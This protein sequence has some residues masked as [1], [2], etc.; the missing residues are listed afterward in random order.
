MNI[1]NY[2]KQHSNGSNSSSH[3]SNKT[4]FV[5]SPVLYMTPMAPIDYGC[6]DDIL[7]D[8]KSDSNMTP[9]SQT[10]SPMFTGENEAFG[11]LEFLDSL[12]FELKYGSH[13]SQGNRK[14]MEDRHKIKIGLDNN[15]H[16]SL[17]GVFDGHGGERASNFVKKKIVNCLN[18]FVKENKAGYSSKNSY[19][20]PTN[21]NCSSSSSTSSTT[22]TTPST[23]SVTSPPSNIISH[24]IN[25]SSS[26]VG[27]SA[28]NSSTGIGGGHC[29][30]NPPNSQPLLIVANAG[31]SRGVLCR[32]G[33]A[34]PL[35]YDHKPGNPKEKQRISSAGGKI[36]WDYNERIWRVSGILSV[37]RGIGDIPL[38]K[39]VICD[40]EFVVFPLKGPSIR[41]NRVH[42][43][44]SSA[45]ASPTSSTPKAFKSSP[46]MNS[47][48]F[49]SPSFKNKPVT[50]SPSQSN[51]PQIFTP[52][53]N[54]S[55]Y[56]QNNGI[57]SPSSSIASETP[58]LNS[59]DHRNHNHSNINNHSL[60][61]P[62]P[63]S[64]SH[65]N[66]H[67][68]HKM[69]YCSNHQF[70]YGEV[71]QFFVLATDGIWDVFENQELVDFINENIEEFYHSKRIDWDANEISKKVVQ[72]AYRRGSGDNTTVLIIKLYW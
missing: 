72:E 65:H 66:H 70:N 6:P 55:N 36:E 71:D 49:F 21:S 12:N 56:Q 26:S 63:S 22:S 25:G 48:F 59:T 2:F 30:Q 5:P 13:V 20:S 9:N 62:P 67:H 8:G 47:R 29:F 24:Q 35:S 27:P 19:T 7:D 64:I 37:S 53:I 46:Q 61:T 3:Y 15:Q 69:Y 16:L 51:S 23:S 34:L 41:R 1:I 11:A 45:S 57:S 40:P 68:Q 52:Y 58:S 17:F 33:K 42:Y 50:G 4:S 10:T 32:N 28:L 54:Q 18:K 60:L 44:S 14:Y 43:T 38:K 39:W 31:D